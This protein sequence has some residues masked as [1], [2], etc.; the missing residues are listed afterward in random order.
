MNRPS[1]CCRMFH[2]WLS[3]SCALAR[4]PSL[5][6]VYS[7]RSHQ[8]PPSPSRSSAAVLTPESIPLDI[9]FQPRHDGLRPHHRFS[10]ID[11]R[12]KINLFSYLLE[13]FGQRVGSTEAQGYVHWCS[14]GAGG[15]RIS[16]DRGCG[17][18]RD[19]P[20]SCATVAPI[21]LAE[22]LI[23][24]EP[25]KPWVTF[26]RNIRSVKYLSTL[27]NITNRKRYI[28]IDIGARN[29]GS[30][31]GSWFQKAYPKQGHNFTVYAIEA[32][33]HAFRQSYINHTE[34][35]FMPFAA[36]VRNE[37]LMFGSDSSG[38]SFTSRH[39][40]MGR[41]HQHVQSGSPKLE[42]DQL[43]EVQGI[44]IAEWIRSV[45][46]EDDFVVVKMDVEGAEYE[47]LPRLMTTGVIC[48]VD[49]LFLECHYNRWQHCC[50][51]RTTKYNRTY[52]DCVSLFRSL[53]QNGVLVHQWW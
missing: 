9:G 22:P 53:R 37:T 43:I 46:S 47:L 41:I 5:F 24:T 13:A 10:T 11:C 23:L 52:Q 12:E 7:F 15:R 17:C 16:G 42:R 20:R 30:S 32:D 40:G 31:I 14:A 3:L 51:E 1:V 36:W 50:P 26:K 48:L 28:Y 2:R 35:N 8:V 38:T 39:V 19:R 44:D 18:N 21:N 27:T 4:L 34:V 25:K 33:H 6:L 29:Y 45:A 49:E